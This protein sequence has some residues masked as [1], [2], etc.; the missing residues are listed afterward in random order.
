[1]VNLQVYETQCCHNSVLRFS[2][3]IEDHAIFVPSQDSIFSINSVRLE[4]VGSQDLADS[5]QAQTILA[6]K[7]LLPHAT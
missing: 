1:M 5:K 2:T 7:R 3:Q 4:N 6:S